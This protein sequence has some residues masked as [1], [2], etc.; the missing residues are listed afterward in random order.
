[1]FF[2]HPSFK[3]IYLENDVLVYRLPAHVAY[4]Y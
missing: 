3:V 4:L 2:I 1:L